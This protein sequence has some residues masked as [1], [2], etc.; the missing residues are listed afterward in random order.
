MSKQ[1]TKPWVLVT[2]IKEKINPEDFERVMP[3]VSALVD[4]R[5]R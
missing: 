5:Q 4:E 1:E 2:T 3:Q